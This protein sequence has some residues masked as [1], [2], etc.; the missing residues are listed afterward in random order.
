MVSDIAL[1]PPRNGTVEI[2]GPDRAPFDEIV[3]T[4]LTDVGDARRV[5]ADPDEPYFGSRV[6]QHSLVPLG[7]ARI[8]P[9]TLAEWIDHKRA[10]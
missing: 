8:G 9:T 4:Y 3:R 5:V 10:A 6:E 2:A 7:E 1:A